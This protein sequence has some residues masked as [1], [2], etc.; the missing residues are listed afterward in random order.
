VHY[1]DVGVNDDVDGDDIYLDLYVWANVF[2]Q[3]GQIKL[4][5]NNVVKLYYHFC[6]Q[7]AST[8]FVCLSPEN[9]FNSWFCY[10]MYHLW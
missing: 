2:W 7:L 5:N 9:W 8:A 3:P 6:F 10:G 4:K 1:D